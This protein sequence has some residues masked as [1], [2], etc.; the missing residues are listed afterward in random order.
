[1]CIEVNS[2]KLLKTALAYDWEGPDYE[3]NSL[4]V[5]RILPSP[6]PLMLFTA[7]YVSTFQISCLYT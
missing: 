1:M 7:L 6:T 5:V 4:E 3:D 2:D